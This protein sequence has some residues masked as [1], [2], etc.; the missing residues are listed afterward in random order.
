MNLLLLDND[1]LTPAQAVQVASGM[2]ELGVAPEST[3][4]VPSDE[5]ASQMTP[6]LP[7]LKLA[8]AVM[9]IAV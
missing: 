3:A 7:A 4:I 2:F 6:I 5:L 8:L 9:T 1:R